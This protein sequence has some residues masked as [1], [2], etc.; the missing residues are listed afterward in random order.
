[1]LQH[2]FQ[3]TLFQLQMSNLFRWSSSSRGFSPCCRSSISVSRI[4]SAAQS[5]SMKAIAGSLKLKLAQYRE[6][7][8]F[9]KFGA[10]LD[11]LQKKH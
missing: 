2:T 3:L 1:M 6:V 8:E 4:G 10:D 11:L 9:A 7:E 5:K